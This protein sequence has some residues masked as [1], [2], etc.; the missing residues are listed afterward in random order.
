MH[1]IDVTLIGSLSCGLLL[2]KDFFII[3]FIENYDLNELKINEN[4]E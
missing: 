2:N 4:L 1:G 3:R